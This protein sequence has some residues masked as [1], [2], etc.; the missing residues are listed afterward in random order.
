MTQCGGEIS[1][2]HATWGLRKTTFSPGS[3]IQR[4]VASSSIFPS[5]VPTAKPKSYAS[6]DLLAGKAAML[7]IVGRDQSRQAS[8][9]ARKICAVNEQ[10]SI[11][12][13]AALEGRGAM[14]I[15]I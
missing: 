13:S 1:V 6:R 10:R 14:A 9:S 11:L 2:T 7:T 12:L 5:V 15:Q 8:R 3:T 4:S